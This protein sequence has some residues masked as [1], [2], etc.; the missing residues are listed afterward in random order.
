MAFNQSLNIAQ[1]N[2]H[3][4][5][6]LNKRENIK[7]YLTTNN[8][9][10]FLIQEIW[11]KHSEKFKFLN[12][13]FFKNCRQEG[14]GGT[15]ILV[16]PA[17][18]A[19]E[20]IIPNVDLE[21][22][23]IKIKN[24]KTPTIFISLY[25]PPESTINE[26]KNPL[27]KLFQ[28]IQHS[29]IPVM[30]G[31]DI[32]AHHPIWDRNITRP[33]RR[34]ELFSDILDNNNI[35]IHNTGDATRW[36]DLNCN[37]SA[38]DI[39][40]T[41]TDIAPFVTWEVS[42]ENLGSDHKLI[43]CKIVDY[44]KFSNNLPYTI[45]SKKLAIEYLNQIDPTEIG[46]VDELEQEIE[47]AINKATFK[48]YPNSK[49]KIKPYWT[50][51]I[52]KL[53]EEKNKKHIQFRKNLTLENKYIFK[54]AER[55][56]NIELKKAVYKYRE[57]KLEEINEDTN[58]QQMWNIVRC[59]AG[60]FKNKNNSEL[61]HNETIAKEFVDNNFVL[62][63]NLKFDPVNSNVD[64]H[65]YAGEISKDVMLKTIQNRKDT[66]AAGSNR[67]SYYFL[68]NI[69]S[70]LL[71]KILEIT[72][73]VWK[74]GIV[75][76]KWQTS[77][78]VPILKPTKDKTKATSYRPI[79]LIN[80]NLKIIN[81]EVKKRL[82]VFAQENNLIPPLS[83]GFKENSSTTDCINYLISTVTE[84]QRN[85]MTVATIFIDLSK[86]F[87]SVD[88]GILLKQLDSFAVP[89]KILRWL[90][91][92]LSERSITLETVNNKLY[93]DTNKGLPQGCPLSPLLFNIYTA[94]LHEI[95]TEKVILEQFA[96]DFA[97]TIVGDS[98]QEVELT[99]NITINRIKEYFESLKIAINPDK[100]AVIVFN[101]RKEEKIKINID[102][103][104]IKQVDQHKYLGYIVDQKLNHIPHIDYITNK[105]KKRLNVLKI[106]CKRKG[107]AHPQTALR[108]NQAI[109]RSQI[110][111]G[112]TVYG[113]VAKTNLNKLNSTF[114]AGLR[115]SLRLVKST[116]I[117]VLY[118]EAG[119]IPIKDRANM[120]AKK[121]S[122]KVFAHNK[123]IIDT[124]SKFTELNELP[125]K[126]TFLEKT[127]YTHNYL[128]IQT[129]CSIIST[130][131]KNKI[132]TIKNININ[133]EIP[134]LNKND[135]NEFTIRAITNEYISNNFKN[136]IKIYTDGSK[137]AESCGIGIWIDNED[138]IKCQVNKELSIMNVELIAI[139]TAIDMINN[140]N[141]ATEFVICS[142]SKSG[143]MSLK[144][145]NI[146][147]NF[148]ILEILLKLS[149]S[150]KHITLQWVPGHRGILGNE[151]AD[152][153]SKQG[154]K[155]TNRIY[156]KLPLTDA[157]N[158]AKK[159]TIEEWK[160]NYTEL[161]QHKGQKHFMIY[162][163]PT[164]KPWFYN[165]AL[166][167]H[168]IINIGRL[169]TFHTMTKDKLYQ[170]KLTNSE[171]CEEC[172]VREDA[173]H[174]LFA[175]TKYLGNRYKH[176]C[177]ITYSNTEDLLKNT[178]TKTYREI[179]NFIKIN[180]IQL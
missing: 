163:T 99:A 157:I 121:E 139:N 28:Y 180:R 25:I 129:N 6:P 49:K 138:T 97:I 109:I 102:N 104:E 172:G 11:I 124:L 116:P 144:H 26:I 35:V 84:A 40:L 77:K 101:P 94:S 92:Y 82:S 19:E 62:E 44:N 64:E 126:H 37:A 80:V 8:I 152:K 167:T 87:D 23:A 52:K 5:R 173:N 67:L 75:P 114:N 85:K 131:I 176:K 161:S 4:L 59:I 136:H 119:E 112:I 111:Y 33:D 158:L 90:I 63:E 159:E 39:T 123:P 34:G 1:I 27:E 130:E 113:G 48:I 95:T 12:Y 137:T 143:L 107:G 43:E 135:M 61:L 174:V 155:S 17:L 74:S 47:K 148:I 73:D 140:I 98:I 179:A 91:S 156:T 50:D 117:N 142:D 38:I 153:L 55:E 105:A 165:Y 54:K 65:R 66:S 103:V 30:L 56:F 177:L 120:L 9:H 110:D 20:I 118:A 169:R 125:K 76:K 16:H 58:T 141:D 127:T 14:Y 96:D 42:E 134:H 57:E 100:T 93:K 51:K 18:I 7:T 150:V 72:N 29:S 83:F 154:C 147:N 164:L 79:A 178:N 128:V 89:N 24:L 170:W 10:L 3:S 69:K 21:V 115:T 78:I 46:N 106:I 122:I 132:D 108:I 15:G 68:K 146:K 22:V 2:I 81:C 151:K 133:T 70:E 171:I 149:Q 31:G 160:R 86:A 32:N 71:N 13:N 168:E 145:K 45:I 60:N 162:P 41:T 36:Q 175:C 166:E 88:I 53:Y